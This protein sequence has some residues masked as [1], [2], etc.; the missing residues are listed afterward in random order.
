MHH[1]GPSSTRART[2]QPS[3]SAGERGP[4]DCL[5]PAHVHGAAYGSRYGRKQ[6][7]VARGPTPPAAHPERWADRTSWRTSPGRPHSPPRGAGRAGPT[8][9]IGD[10]AIERQGTQDRGDQEFQ[11]H[12]GHRDKI[13]P[14]SQGSP[15][16]A[17]E[18]SDQ[19]TAVPQSHQ[20]TSKGAGT[21]HQRTRRRRHIL[22]T[23][24]RHEIRSHT[25]TT[26]HLIRTTLTDDHESSKITKEVSPNDWPPMNR[27]GAKPWER[28]GETPPPGRGLTTPQGSPRS[29]GERRRTARSTGPRRPGTA[30]SC[31]W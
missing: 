24:P 31:R 21:P 13:I 2:A 23:P 26:E 5:R 12:L 22:R 9:R 6:Y 27:L 17:T 11:D 7:S 1:M 8:R 14:G 20:P 4:P 25:T 10:G 3:Q 18:H 28:G 30:R 15:G 29:P 19:M 16:T